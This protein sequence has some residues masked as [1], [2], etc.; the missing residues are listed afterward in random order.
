MSSNLARPSSRFYKAKTDKSD[1]NFLCICAF[2]FEERTG[3]LITN[4][5]LR[6][7]SLKCSVFLT[8]DLTDST[9]QP[10]MMYDEA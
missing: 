6:S 4:L 1:D 5:H 10:C 9:K 3:E 2:H 8:I 7:L